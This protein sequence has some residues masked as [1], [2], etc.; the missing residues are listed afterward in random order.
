[1]TSFPNKYNLYDLY[2][3]NGEFFLWTT[4]QRLMMMMAMRCLALRA[5]FSSVELVF[6]FSNKIELQYLKKG[7]DSAFLC[8]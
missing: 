6:A 2:S 4:T 1:M 3:S 7:Q 5:A 8:E